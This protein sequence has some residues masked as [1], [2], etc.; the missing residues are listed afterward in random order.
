MNYNKK[1]EPAL[2]DDKTERKKNLIQTRNPQLHLW[3]SFLRLILRDLFQDQSYT[4]Y[5]VVRFAIHAILEA[6]FTAYN[7]GILFASVEFDGEIR[8]FLP[9]CK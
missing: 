8:I 3:P 1:K 7:T 2:K 4:E 5:T 9:D 6:E